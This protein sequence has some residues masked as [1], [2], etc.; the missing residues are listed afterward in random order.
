MYKWFLMLNYILL[1]WRN[2]VAARARGCCTWERVRGVQNGVHY[3]EPV[4]DRE[5][6]AGDRR[7]WLL[8]SPKSAALPRSTA[9]ARPPLPGLSHPQEFHILLSAF[10]T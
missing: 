10:K 2:A 4:G 9:A 8:R 6:V 5:M 7:E 1:Q 3:F